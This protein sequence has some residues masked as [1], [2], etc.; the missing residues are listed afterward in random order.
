MLGF[1]GNR[2]ESPLARSVVAGVVLTAAGWLHGAEPETP[3]EDAVHASANALNQDEWKK[4]DAASEELRGKIFGVLAAKNPPSESLEALHERFGKKNSPFPLEVRY[5]IGDALRHGMDVSRDMA[6]MVETGTHSGQSLL[7]QLSRGGTVVRAS[8]DTAEAVRATRVDI[9]HGHRS[10]TMA[11]A[12]LCEATGTVP[13]S[14]EDAAYELVP[15]PE[16]ARYGA[17]DFAL[18]V[19]VPS[20]TARDPSVR[21]FTELN[22]HA[23]GELKDAEGRVGVDPSADWSVATKKREDWTSDF[24]CVQGSVPTEIA[25]RPARFLKATIATRPVEKTM[26]PDVR[27]EI[28]FQAMAFS[29]FETGDG[30]WET[31][32]EGELLI[33]QT[34]D[35]VPIEEYRAVHASNYVLVDED[36]ATIPSTVGITNIGGYVFDVHVASAKR[37]ARVRVTAYERVGD[38]KIPVPAIKGFEPAVP[39]PPVARS[40]FE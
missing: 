34:N 22:K 18:A 23:V 35:R 26:E 3:I 6:T 36:G 11:L 38:Y 31:V 20:D 15:A 2:Q 32:V 5:R 10:F 39:P 28:G 1:H 16:G 13:D 40:P 12:I 19:L 8:K 24:E 25:Q 21:L 17:N 27:T 30:S 9:D 33:P 7:D 4:R 37:P 14:T 29:S